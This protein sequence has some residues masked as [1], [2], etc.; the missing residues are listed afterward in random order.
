MSA[1]RETV[2]RAL[3]IVPEDEWGQLP[4]WAKDDACKRAD[5]AIAAVREHLSEVTMAMWWAGEEAAFKAQ[6]SDRKALEEV[7][8][9]TGGVPASM[10][11]VPP[12]VWRAMLAAAFEDKA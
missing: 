3:G 1:L 9:R 8:A 12:A 7:K 2:A 6:R 10:S 11:S 5:A 4:K